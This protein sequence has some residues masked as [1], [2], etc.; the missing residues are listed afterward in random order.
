MADAGQPWTATSLALC[1]R[2]ATVPT[3]RTL[4][5]HFVVRTLEYVRTPRG[6]HGS[7]RRLLRRWHELTGTTCRDWQLWQSLEELRRLG[8]LHYERRQDGLVIRLAEDLPAAGGSHDTLPVVE[9]AGVPVAE[10]DL[11]VVERAGV[12][13][14]ERAGCG[15]TASRIP[16]ALCKIDNADPIADPVQRGSFD[17]SSYLSHTAPS[18]PGSGV[19]HNFD[20][21]V[22]HRGRRRETDASRQAAETE[23]ELRRWRAD[24][25]ATRR[26]VAEREAALA[27][28]REH[29]ERRP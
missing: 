15:N 27:Y 16:S 17:R 14:V 3:S 29:R 9:R 20:I 5:L 21:E 10:T 22:R 19:S 23:R 1:E 26:M 2:L 8:D 25:A 7:M 4:R 13:V 18:S 24:E 28:Q 11:P 12:P 6:W